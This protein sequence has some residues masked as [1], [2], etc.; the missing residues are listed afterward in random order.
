MT[1]FNIFVYMKTDYS[2]EDRLFKVVD[3]FEILVSYNLLKIV[4]KQH[5]Y[6]TTL[7]TLS[8]I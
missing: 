6:S 3:A 7:N 1:G 4:I 2:N 8:H 5:H